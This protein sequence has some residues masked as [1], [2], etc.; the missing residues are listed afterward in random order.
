MNTAVI[1]I[2]LGECVCLW[3]GESCEA[4]RPCVASGYASKRPHHEGYENWM[5]D[6]ALQSEADCVT[7]WRTWFGTR[8]ALQ[9]VANMITTA[10]PGMHREV[11]RRK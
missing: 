4:R 3:I 9:I 1:T 8:Y 2:M 6:E 5:M 11:S 10:T 7:M